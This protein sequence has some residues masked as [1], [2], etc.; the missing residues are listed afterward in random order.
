[1]KHITFRNKISRLYCYCCLQ[2]VRQRY[3]W[4]CVHWI[5]KDVGV[6]IA[7]YYVLYG[8]RETATICEEWRTIWSHSLS[9]CK[10]FE[11]YMIGSYRTMVARDF[12]LQQ[13]L[14]VFLSVP[15]LW[16]LPVWTLGGILFKMGLSVFSSVCRHYPS[17]LKFWT[18]DCTVFL[19]LMYIPWV[20]WF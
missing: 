9:F 14:S 1:M 12:L 8:T 4:N 7:N 5:W 17:V 20:K 19:C 11:V 2:A 13:F 10:S 15:I 16:L 6:Y 18:V 3:D